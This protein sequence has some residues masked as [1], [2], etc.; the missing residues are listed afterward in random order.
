MGLY[1]PG[2]LNFFTG[3]KWLPLPDT[4][5]AMER[6]ELGPREPGSPGVI[7]RQA[8]NTGSTLDKSRGAMSCW[9]YLCLARPLPGGI[10]HLD[11]SPPSVHKVPGPLQTFLQNIFTVNI[12]V[13]RSGNSGLSWQ[14]FYKGEVLSCFCSSPTLSRSGYPHVF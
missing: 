4:W 13:Q 2:Y 7:R 3:S 12:R 5:P 9:V 11:P 10:G 6:E 14:A 8:M 1:L